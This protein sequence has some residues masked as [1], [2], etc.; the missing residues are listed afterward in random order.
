M[1]DFREGRLPLNCACAVDAG[2]NEHYPRILLLCE[3]H[4]QNCDDNY[5]NCY[6]YT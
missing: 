3:N 1:I 6:Y 4:V 5:N 2:K